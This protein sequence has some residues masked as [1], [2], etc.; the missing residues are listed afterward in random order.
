MTACCRK[1]HRLEQLA[2]QDVVHVDGFVLV[3]QLLDDLG[4]AR[5]GTPACRSCSSRERVE[6]EAFIDGL[7]YGSAVERLTCRT[8]CESSMKHYLRQMLEQQVLD[9]VETTADNGTSLVSPPA[10]GDLNVGSALSS[11]RLGLITPT[12]RAAVI[13][14]GRAMS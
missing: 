8:R 5:A 11:A 6:D 12:R 10:C 14:T 4:H 3:A 7:A 13:D 1:R 2:H 9:E